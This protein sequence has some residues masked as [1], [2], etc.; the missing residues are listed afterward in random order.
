MTTR[1]FDWR[2][3]CPEDV[4]KVWP[5]VAG[6][7]RGKVVDVAAAQDARRKLEGRSLTRRERPT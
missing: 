3:D 2:R 7:G 6:K 4:A 5:P 1:P